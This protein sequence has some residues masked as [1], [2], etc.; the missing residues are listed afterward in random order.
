MTNP[1]DDAWA[2]ELMKNDPDYQ[3]EKAQRSIK[4]ALVI[5][6]LPRLGKILHD[7]WDYLDAL[8]RKLIRA[9]AEG[10]L[11]DLDATSGPRVVK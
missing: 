9:Y 6:E 2:E 7:N 8:D 4:Q 3:R 5:N 1:T 10:W 11:A